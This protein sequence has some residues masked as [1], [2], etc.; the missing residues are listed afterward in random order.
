ML[1]AAGLLCFMRFGA[2]GLP[3]SSQ[4]RPRL[5]RSK[6]PLRAAFRFRRAGRR[7]TARL[8]LR[9]GRSRL[10]PDMDLRSQCFACLHAWS[11]QVRQPNRPARRAQ[12]TWI[13][14]R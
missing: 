1:L 5:L 7:C 11:C 4:P 6:H 8:R 10:R 9:D 3:R 13:V 12:R 2:C 14:S